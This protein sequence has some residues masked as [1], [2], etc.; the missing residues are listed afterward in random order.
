MTD[1]IPPSSEAEPAAHVYPEKASSMAVAA[2]VLGLLGTCCC[3]SVFGGIPALVLGFIEKKKVE[4]GESSQ[5]SFGFAMAG[6]V[7]GA[8][9]CLQLILILL[10]Y[11]VVFMII[12]GG[13]GDFLGGLRSLS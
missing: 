10:Y 7:L 3:C 4:R 2:F 8:I 11:I 5:R 6:I 1:Y 13:K 12:M 9:S